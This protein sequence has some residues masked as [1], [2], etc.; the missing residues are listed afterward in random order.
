MADPNV[1]KGKRALR[2]DV[3][4]KARDVAVLDGDILSVLRSLERPGDSVSFLDDVID[5]FVEET[6]GILDS[7]VEAIRLNGL[8][9]ILHYSHQLKGFSGN[10]GVSRLSSLCEAIEDHAS[11]LEEY[12]SDEICILLTQAY[13][14]AIQELENDWKR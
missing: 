4:R 9:S 12:D 1:N 6:P 14:N 3:F 8:A 11:A 7:L 5:S 13:T 2:D 10:I